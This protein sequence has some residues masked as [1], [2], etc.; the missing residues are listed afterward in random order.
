MGT[1]QEL[2]SGIGG[3][4][5]VGLVAREVWT[6]FKERN[7]AKQAAEERQRIA[8]QAAEEKKTQAETAQNTEEHTANAALNW[9][10]EW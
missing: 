3:T 9:L 7:A 5:A 1:L 10:E 4:A 2:F 6:Y 8:K